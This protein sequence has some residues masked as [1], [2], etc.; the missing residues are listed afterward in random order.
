VEVLYQLGEQD[1]IAGIEVHHFNQ[2][3]VADILAMIETLGDRTYRRRV[4]A[5]GTATG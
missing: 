1:R 5:G 4:G 3:S 2:R